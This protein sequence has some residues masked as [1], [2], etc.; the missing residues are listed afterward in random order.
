MNEIAENGG[1]SEGPEIPVPTSGDAYR[2]LLARP[3]GGAYMLPVSS[4]DITAKPNGSHI[5]SIGT[6]CR[7]DLSTTYSSLT[8]AI[9]SNTPIF[10]DQ[11]YWPKANVRGIPAFSLEGHTGLGEKKAT[12]IGSMTITTDGLLEFYPIEGVTP[13]NVIATACWSTI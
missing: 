6:Q 13:K 3:G 11:R 12:L 10:A 9:Q 2:P 7:Y 1:D 4:M 5:Y 8:D